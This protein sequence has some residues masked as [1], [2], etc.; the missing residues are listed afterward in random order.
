[1]KASS[2]WSIVRNLTTKCGIIYTNCNYLNL[3]N[4]TIIPLQ[5]VHTHSCGPSYI[6]LDQTNNDSTFDPILFC[7]T[8]IIEESINFQPWSELRKM[9]NK[10]FKLICGHASFSG[11]QILWNRNNMWTDEVEK[12]VYRGVNSCSD[13]AKISEPNRAQKVSL[14][15]VNGS[16]NEV[17][18]IDHFHLANLRNFHIMDASR[19]YSVGISFLDT[20]MGAAIEVSDSH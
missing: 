20:E 6:F 4:R 1:M 11:I 3:S 8:G 9:I 19:R 18:C 16:F 12:V 13:C 5:N 14:T 2:Q 10:V 7:T 17:M 15:W